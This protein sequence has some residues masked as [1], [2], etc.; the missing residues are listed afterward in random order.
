[1]DRSIEREIERARKGRTRLTCDMTEA[2]WY[3]P[4]LLSK[5]LVFPS[6]E[7]FSMWLKGFFKLYTF[8]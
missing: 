8:S 7:M 5:K 6:K 1:M 3:S 4:T 2:F